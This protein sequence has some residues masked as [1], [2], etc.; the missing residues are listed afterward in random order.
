MKVLKAQVGGYEGVRCEISDMCN[1]KR[2]MSVA[3]EYM[4]HNSYR[5]SSKKLGS[6]SILILLIDG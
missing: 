4:M 2:G 5:K 3:I 6:G 1:Y